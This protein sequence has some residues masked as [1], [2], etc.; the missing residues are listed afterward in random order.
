MLKSRIKQL[1]RNMVTI[2]PSM[3]YNLG[4]N[5]YRLN[6]YDQFALVPADKAEYNIVCKAH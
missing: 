3:C 1:K 2:Y 4:K 6:A 5:N